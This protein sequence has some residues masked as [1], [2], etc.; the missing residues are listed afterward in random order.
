MNKYTQ[1]EINLI[2]QIPVIHDMYKYKIINDNNL[3]NYFTTKMYDLYL[4]FTNCIIN[5]IFDIYLN[6]SDLDIIDYIHFIIKTSLNIDH[7]KQILKYVNHSNFNYLS[8]FLEKKEI[9]YK[10]IPLL[11]YDL[12]K[13][14]IKNSEL[15]LS[16]VLNYL[17]D[18][19]PKHIRGSSVSTQ[20]FYDKIYISNLKEPDFYNHEEFEEAWIKNKKYKY[21][22]ISDSLLIFIGDVKYFFIDNALYI[23]CDNL[24]LYDIINDVFFD[25]YIVFKNDNTFYNIGV[26]YIIIGGCESVDDLLISCKLNYKSIAV[27]LKNNIKNLNDKPILTCIQYDN[28]RIFKMFMDKN[29]KILIVKCLSVC[30]KYNKIEIMEYILLKSKICPTIIYKLL[31][32]NIETVNSKILKYFSSSVDLH[33]NYEEL[34]IAAL[35]TR[36]FEAISFL[37]SI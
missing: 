13:D 4:F 15:K 25:E 9:E 3:F 6:I 17:Y 20:I 16:W 12:V 32:L 1:E 35:K 5:D 23:Y 33:Q 19:H 37:Q 24:D 8:M 34:L 7:Y 28:I 26:Y 21:Y 22:N 29:D 11:K 30:M 36:N 2:K 10:I 27:F 18:I 14:Y 31:L